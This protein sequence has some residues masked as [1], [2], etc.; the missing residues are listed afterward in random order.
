VSSISRS[1]RQRS[2]GAGV[3]D[4]PELR[5]ASGDAGM[6][7]ITRNSTFVGGHSSVGPR[8]TRTPNL[9]IKSPRR[10]VHPRPRS[11]IPSGHGPVTVHQEHLDSR[12]SI[13]LAVNLAVNRWQAQSSVP[14]TWSSSTDMLGRLA[15]SV[16]DDSRWT[17]EVPQ[18]VA[19]SPRSKRQRSWPGPPSSVSLPETPSTAFRPSTPGPP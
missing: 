2:A 11:S 13:H 8:G 15:R 4:L 6:P 18:L 7:S 1:L 12:L 17:Y 9:R 19:T 16:A 10:A 3:K 14:R 5:Q